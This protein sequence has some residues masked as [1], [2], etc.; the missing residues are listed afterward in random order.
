MPR[1]LRQDIVDFYHG[2]PVADPYRWL[3]EPN[4]P[5][6]QAWS[7]EQNATARAHLDAI[8]VRDDVR[9]RLQD[10]WQFTHRA[11][12]VKVANRY[13]SLQR[14]AGR[15]QPALYAQD[16]LDGP[17]TLVLDPQTWSEEGTVTI[18]GLSFT[19]DGQYLA[20]AR[21]SG[22]SDWQEI[23]I[24]SL[25]DGTD[26]P[27]VLRWCKFTHAAWAHDG[28]GF[29]YAR[30]PEPGSAA[31]V[32]ESR[33]QRLYWHQTGT[34]QSEDPLVYERP[35]HPEWSFWPVMTHDGKY[36][37]VTVQ[38]GTDSRNRIYYREASGAGP[39]IALL[40]AADASY[41]FVGNDGDT[42]Y[43]LTDLD[44]PRG[45]VVAIDLSH[46]APDAWRVVIPEQS[47]ALEQVT[48]A[49]GHWV[50]VYLHDACH[51]VRLYT[52]DGRSAGDIELPAPGAVLS[53][54]SD[55]EDA[56]WFLS[57]ASFLHPPAI[58][59]GHLEQVGLSLVDAAEIDIDLSRYE[60]RQV[61]YHSQDGTRIPMFLTHRKGMTLDGDNPV[62][63]YGYGGFNIS[64]TPDFSVPPL[65]WLERGGVYAVANLRGGSEY[66]EDWHRAGMLGNKQNVFDDFIAAAEW[67]IDNNYTRSSRLAIM[68]RSNGGLLVAACM[69][70]RPDLFGAVVCVVPVTDMLR[71]HHFTVGRFWTPEYGNAEETP[72]HFQF[73]H[74]YSPLHNVKAGTVYPPILIPTAEGDDRVVPSHAKKFAATLQHADGPSPVLVRIDAAAGHGAGKPVTKLVEEYADVYAFLIDTLHVR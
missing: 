38:E 27:E 66:G 30:Y 41:S 8:E 43:F 34:P 72:A 36:I 56:E 58:Y 67:L 69:T 10:L 3:E 55:P 57:F 60:T 22:G 47:D 74:Q 12:P 19:Q 52:L 33:N 73:L 65:V 6:T 15:N 13:Y 11:A 29:Y 71:Y 31:T 44:A 61:F 42:F 54:T 7:V 53:L 18:T 37:V 70:Q 25:A 59:R 64:L 39:L 40:D 48:L 5:D 21:S 45:R 46:A 63:L 62:L 28:S 50:A 49:G 23:R 16:A 51:T 2:V 35:D 24:R 32:D 20:Y 14:D 17:L 68:G 9:R 1:S 26:A 4:S